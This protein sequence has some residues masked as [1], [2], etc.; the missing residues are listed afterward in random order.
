MSLFGIPKVGQTYKEGFY[1]AAVGLYLAIN[2]ASPYTLIVSEDIHIC[3][4]RR[5]AR[6][7]GQFASKSAANSAVR[8]P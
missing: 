4:S 6:R 3:C 1:P 8:Y 2:F 7:F 5:R